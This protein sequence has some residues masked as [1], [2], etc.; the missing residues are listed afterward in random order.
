MH[1][2]TLNSLCSIKYVDMPYISNL[3]VWK[4]SILPWIKD[5]IADFKGKGLFTGQ[6]IL[7]MAIVNSDYEFVRYLLKMDADIS[8]KA[9]GEFFMPMVLRRGHVEVKQERLL[10]RFLKYVKLQH[11]DDQVGDS[12]NTE[13]AFEDPDLYFGQ[14]PLSFAVCTGQHTVCDLLKHY[15]FKESK[16]LKRKDWSG[17]INAKDDLGNTALVR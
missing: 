10:A 15:F 13:S 8:A 1:M 6:T 2:L 11:V 4:H 9:V 5:D 16:I 14:F 3:E 12:T 17:F 7:H